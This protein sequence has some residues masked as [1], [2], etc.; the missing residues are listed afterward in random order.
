MARRR[1]PPPDSIGS[2][3][4]NT[5]LNLD[6]LDNEE[7][8]TE[9]DGEPTQE[10]VEREKDVFCV[11]KSYVDCNI[12]F[13]FHIFK[14]ST[15]KGRAEW[16]YSWTALQEEYGGG[17]FRVEL[18][19][20][21]NNRVR[22]TQSLNVDA[23]K[24]DPLAAALGAQAPKAGEPASQSIGAFD[25][26]TAMEKM[27]E[28]SK[29][30]NDEAARS[31]DKEQ[32]G[33]FGLIVQMMQSSAASQS[34]VQQESTRLLMTLMGE[35]SKSQAAMFAA[36]H[37]GKQDKSPGFLEILELAD[38]KAAAARDESARMYAL[39]DKKADEKAEIYER[40]ADMQ[41]KVE[42]KRGDGSLV[43]KLIEGIFPLA[44]QFMETSAKTA[45]LAATQPQAVGGNGRVVA[46]ANPV[47]VIE[48][49]K[50]PT[51]KEKIEKVI[52]AEVEAGI[53][54]SK[55]PEETAKRVQTLLSQQGVTLEQA[56][57]LFPKADLIGQAKAAGYP[58]FVVTWLERFYDAAL[59]TIQPAAAA[60]LSNGAAA[61]SDGATG[62]AET[63]PVL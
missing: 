21:S 9:G 43:D 59:P 22:K 4:E 58:E 37:T 3:I 62:A 38:R 61:P 23:P 50:E 30:E 35:Q 6:E 31:R 48:Q 17:F 8:E 56:K 19:L 52:G 26:L 55:T 34:A 12:P 42:S 45:A 39:V 2:V 49:R 44:K 24:I 60:P 46:R 28:T 7:L 10:D 57:I 14:N 47:R 63:A 15:L 18:K 1:S 29:K 5:E 32:M 36:M 53:K 27:R 16:P 51:V 54:S 41:V 13:Y 40:I 11:A 33:M 20:A 25:F